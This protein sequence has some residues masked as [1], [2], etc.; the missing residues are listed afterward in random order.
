LGLPFAVVFGGE[1][2]S[3]GD[4]SAARSRV[5]CGDTGR[6]I[7]LME[8]GHGCWTRSKSRVDEADRMLDMGFMP[9]IRRILFASSEARHIPFFSATLSPEILKLAKDMVRDPV[10]VTNLSGQPTVDKI[11]RRSCSSTSPTN[12]LLIIC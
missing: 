7:D 4:R 9:D 2:V 3:A 12:S 10:Q 5:G 1:P 6:L 11:N 8:Q